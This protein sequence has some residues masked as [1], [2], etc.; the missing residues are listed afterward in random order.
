RFLIT[1]WGGG[2]LRRLRWARG[3]SD[4]EYEQLN[5]GRRPAAAPNPASAPLI[6]ALVS[7]IAQEK[8]NI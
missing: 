3:N 8:K 7:K 4:L 1:C 5:K 6:T 2:T